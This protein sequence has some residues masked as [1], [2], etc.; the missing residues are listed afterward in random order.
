MTKKNDAPLGKSANL[1]AMLEMLAATIDAR[2][3]EDTN[4]DTGQNTG[5]SYTA[6]LLAKGPSKIAKKIIEEG[7]ELGLALVSEDDAAV[8]AE[9]SDVLYHL[10][11]GL[12]GRGISLDAVAAI[13]AAREGI[14]G[15][16]EKASRI[17]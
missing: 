7:G 8:A 9:A 13:L 4:E 16:D 5:N 6:Q 14:S 17:D 15:L 11:V 1:A 3:S 12:R 2:A 10:L